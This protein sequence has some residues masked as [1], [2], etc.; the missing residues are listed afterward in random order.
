MEL[1]SREKPG[2]EA[3]GLYFFVEFDTLSKELIK[4]DKA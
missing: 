1:S 4:K 2:R 3:S